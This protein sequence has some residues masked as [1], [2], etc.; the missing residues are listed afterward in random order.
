MMVPYEEIITNF[1]V[2]RAPAC[3]NWKLSILEKCRSPHINIDISSLIDTLIFMR[4]G[5][6]HPYLPKISEYL[7]VVNSEIQNS[8]NFSR[9]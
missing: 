1:G 7:L 2:R 9:R 4:N 3:K 6:Y 5:S 8:F